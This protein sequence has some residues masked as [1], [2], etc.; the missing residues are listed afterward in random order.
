M[1]ISD[2][3][4]DVC[5]SD[6][7]GRDPGLSG[8]ALHRSRVGA[9]RADHRSAHHSGGGVMSLHRVWRVGANIDTDALAPGAYMKLGID[10]IARHCLENRYP[11]LASCSICPAWAFAR[12]TRL[13]RKSTRLNSSH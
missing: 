5:S 1:R 6:L 10:Q 8:F 11:D 3:S 7:L 13:D 2:W 9:D 12:N 4:S